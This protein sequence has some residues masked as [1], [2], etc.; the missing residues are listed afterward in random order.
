MKKQNFIILMGSDGAG[1]STLA[2]GLNDILGYPVEHHGPVKSHSE[3]YNEYFNDVKRINYSVI[4]DRFYEGERIFA[5]LYRGYEATYFPELEKKINEKFNPLLVMVRPS[6][7]T[8]LKRLN[9]RGEDF[10]QPEHF[11]HCYDKVTEIFNDS[12]LPKIIVDTERFTADE[13]IHKIIKRILF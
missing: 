8:I 13:N 1:K 10:V 6:F 7:E 12:L 11:A 9:E 5:P 2:Q 4:K 3:G